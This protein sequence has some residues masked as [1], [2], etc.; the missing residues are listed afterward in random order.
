MRAVGSAILTI[1]GISH[2]L[3]YLSQKMYLLQQLSFSRDTTSP[4]PGY[5]VGA[6]IH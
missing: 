4:Y 2:S 5:P 6:T 1:G 3:S